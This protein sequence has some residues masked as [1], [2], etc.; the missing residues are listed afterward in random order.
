MYD[1][2]ALK[3]SGIVPKLSNK[4]MSDFSLALALQVEQID[5]LVCLV[6]VVIWLKIC[7]GLPLGMRSLES[8]ALSVSVSLIHRTEDGYRMRPN[9]QHTARGLTVSKRAVF[10]FD[11]L[12]LFRIKENIAS[13]GQ[14]MSSSRSMRA[15]LIPFTGTQ[16]RNV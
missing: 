5:S 2:R 3:K 11:K 4:L 8:H 16:S 15:R 14:Y 6:F 7:I 9:L 12:E 1:V 10:I 13:V